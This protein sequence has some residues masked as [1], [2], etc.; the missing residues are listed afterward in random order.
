MKLKSIYKT[1]L[2]THWLGLFAL[3]FITSFLFN[4]L[5]DE[6]VQTDELFNDYLVEQYEYK[7]EGYEEFADDLNNLEFLDE[8]EAIDPED[9]FYEALFILLKMIITIPILATIF[10]SGFFLTNDL[11]RIR[12]GL[13]FKATLISSFIFLL[14]LA[15]RSL[16]FSVFKP[17]Y[18]FEEV[19]NFKPFHLISLFDQ[20]R[21]NDWLIPI[22]DLI[23]VYDLAFLASFAYIISFVKRISFQKVLVPAVISYLIATVLWEFFVLYLFKLLL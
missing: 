6:F 14:E 19:G 3:Y 23:N 15:I 20:E 18:T 11:S 8:S 12:H 22:I 10:L 5:N 16:Y 21:I 4:F 9:L 1:L 2:K 7:Y 13:A 17:I